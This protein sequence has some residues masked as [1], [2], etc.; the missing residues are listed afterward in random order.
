[1]AED[2]NETTEAT[3][4]A[5]NT[6]QVYDFRLYKNASFIEDST[7]FAKNQTTGYISDNFQAHRYY[8]GASYSSGDHTV[9]SW[10]YDNYPTSE[11]WGV[12]TSA[13][14]NAGPKDY[15]FRSA[16]DQGLRLGGSITDGKYVSVR[17]QV[18]AA[19][20]YDVS[21]L[22]GSTGSK[23]DVY[24][25]P[26]TTEYT[27][28]T[29]TSK[30]N[31]EAAMG[32]AANQLANDAALTGNATTALGE[33]TLEA[34]DYIVVF[35]AV[36]DWSNGISVRTLTLTPAA[37]TPEQPAPPSRTSPGGIRH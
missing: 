33:V 19:G 30:A 10:F 26:A 6:E 25:F 28:S 27:A 11:N 34:G 36:G 35:K 7:T 2:N 24:I 20:A 3:Q 21:L 9:A 31:I 17:I 1:M 5:G 12:E 16:S 32:V 15:Y 8:D 29:L 4:P 18:S 37:G 23:A 13:G 14:Q 22:A